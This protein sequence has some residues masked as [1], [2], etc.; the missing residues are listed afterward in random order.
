MTKPIVIEKYDGQSGLHYYE[1][2]NDRPPLV[3][4][5]AQGVDALS[6]GKHFKTL[7]KS[8]HVYAIDCPGHGGS[9]HDASGYNVK[10]IAKSVEMLIRKETDRKI[11]L[12]GHS[13]G[14]LI[15][16]YLAAD[17]ELCEKLILED[18][19]FFSSQGERRFKTFNYV[20]L[21]SVCHKFL[22]EAEAGED[23][24]FYYFRNQYAWNLFPE[25][26]REKVRQKLC[27]AAAKYR[28]KHPE[29]NLKVPFW[30][31]SALEAFRGMDKYDPRFGES[32]HDDSFHCGIPHEEI[33][34]GIRCE[35]VFLKAKTGYNPGGILLAA[36]NEEDT[37]RVCRLIP[38][39][40]LL[41]FNCGHN[42]HGEKP[43]EFIRI[44]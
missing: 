16:A 21:S 29:K 40:K 15:A 6:Y 19:P 20:D 22:M 10:S 24:I 7:S 41:R 13:S 2:P 12:L 43:K 11:T 4:L 36:L 38:N 33:L 28:S 1:T 42:I 35:T 34:A 31:K 44:L 18:P 32:F 27:E 9:S 14:G 8:Y 26:S 25:K 23:F 39:C 30:P 17:S 5:H 3:L 37:E